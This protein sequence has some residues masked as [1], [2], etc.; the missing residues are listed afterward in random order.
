MVQLAIA[1][2]FIVFDIITG[3]VKALYHKDV[4]SSMLRKG[5]FHKLSEFL[6]L[7]G[8][9]LLNYVADYINLGF[10]LPLLNVVSVY[11]CTMELISIVEN[12]CEVNPQMYALFSPYLKKLKK[13]DG[14]KVDDRD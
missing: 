14:D 1:S 6:T 11:I 7:V 12:I 10:E 13:K 9:F 8:S 5:L 3:F 2:G 4:D